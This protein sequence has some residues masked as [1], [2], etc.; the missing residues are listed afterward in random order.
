MDSFFSFI[1]YFST[2]YENSITSGEGF[3]DDFT[4]SALPFSG[5]K[6]GVIASDF[7]FIAILDILVGIFYEQ[8]KL[9]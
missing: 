2:P 9:D 7:I 5:E 1:I 6:K 3:I 4:R 8:F